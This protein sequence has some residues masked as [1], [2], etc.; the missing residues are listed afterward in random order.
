M[1][2]LQLIVDR[3]RF[4]GVSFGLVRKF[5]KQILIALE[6]LCRPDVDVV[7]CDLKPE[8]IVSR[9]SVC[10]ISLDILDREYSAVA[11]ASSKAKCSE[12]HRLWVIMSKNDATLHLH[13]E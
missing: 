11:S 13:P 7:H 12:N 8:N 4:R 3:H 6:F 10:F 1:S 9:L 2:Y 5:G